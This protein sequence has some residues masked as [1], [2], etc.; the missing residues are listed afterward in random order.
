PPAPHPF[1]T[2]RSSDMPVILPIRH[3]PPL[4]ANLILAESPGSEAIELDVLI[5]GAGPAGLACAI[6]LARRSPDL[7]IGVLEKAE[8]LGEHTLSGAVINPVALRELF[9]DIPLD[10]M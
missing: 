6:D 3:Q 4:P 8:S 9:P 1:P 10:Q 7:A 2:R 5:V